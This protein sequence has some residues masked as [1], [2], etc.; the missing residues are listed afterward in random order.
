MERGGGGRWEG[1]TGGGGGGRGPAAGNSRISRQYRGRYEYD[2]AAG[3]R[4]RI[5]LSL[6]NPL[7]P[8]GRQPSHPF[9]PLLGGCTRPALDARSSSFQ[10][11]PVLC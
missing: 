8:P 3:H 5:P 7:V 4:A 9:L 6:C 10:H 2:T 11:A 1:E